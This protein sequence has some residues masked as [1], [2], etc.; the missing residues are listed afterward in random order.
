MVVCQICGNKGYSKLLIHCVQ[1]QDVA[2]H[3][4]CV[5]SPL[6]FEDEEL[7]WSC[8][9]CEPG[10]TKPTTPNKKSESLGASVEQTALQKTVP[11]KLRN[12][13]RLKKS[14]VALQG[15]TK[16]NTDLSIVNQKNR[17][18]TVR[19]KRAK[20]KKTG[21]TNVSECK[22]EL[23]EGKKRP[24]QPKRPV[25][26]KKGKSIKD[27][28]SD[29]GVKKGRFVSVNDT[30]QN[31]K[32]VSL[33]DTAGD[34]LVKTGK[35]VGP[36][37]TEVNVSTCIAGDG[38]QGD[39]KL[40]KQQKRTRRLRP[41]KKIH[42]EKSSCEVFPEHL[43]ELDTSKNQP[44]NA[45]LA[46]TAGDGSQ[47]DSKL[48]KQQKLT[49]CSLPKK[50]IHTEKSSCEVF[51]EHLQESDICK[52]Q[53]RNADLADT[54][55]ESNNG[56]S[57][58]AKQQNL[59]SRLLPKK[60]IHI[61][62]SSCEVFSEH[63]K[64]S[65]TS[66]NQP[67]NADLAD[68]AGDGSQGASKSVKQQKPTSRSLPKKKIDTEKSS[69]EDFSKHLKE[70]D[71]SENQPRNTVLA[72]HADKRKPGVEETAV[73]LRQQDDVQPNRDVS[74]CRAPRRKRKYVIEM[75][76]S[77]EDPV[78]VVAEH[79]RLLT[80][81]AKYPLSKSSNGALSKLS[82]DGLPQLSS[83]ESVPTRPSPRKV[84]DRLL[85][86]E[87]SVVFDNYISSQPSTSLVDHF[88]TQPLIDV[89]WRGY[90]DID[91]NEYLMSL[92]LRAHL[93]NKAHE[94][95]HDAVTLLPKL[96]NFNFVPK[97]YAWPK[98]FEESP[99]T[100]NAIGLYLFPDDERAEELYDGLVHKM[101]D[102]DLALNSIVD[103]LE[104]LV[105]CSIE[106]PRE[107]WSFM[108]KYYLWGVFR[109]MKD[110]IMPNTQFSNN[111]NPSDSFYHQNPSSRF[112]NTYFRQEPV[113]QLVNLTRPI[114]PNPHYRPYNNLS[115]DNHWKHS[116]G[117]FWEPQEHEHG[118]DDYLPDY[119]ERNRYYR[120][121]QEHEHRHDADFSDYG[122]RN[123]YYRGRSDRRNKRAKNWN[124]RDRKYA[125]HSHKLY[126]QSG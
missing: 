112:P 5:L 28:I 21:S 27:S 81:V 13:S 49:S 93:S 69:C 19:R 101:I 115:F 106:L 73:V 78:F 122:K 91:D 65:D 26:A 70:S 74:E 79:S 63:S 126:L 36:L 82:D 108:G 90:C 9:F 92:I 2:A 76:Y 98:S 62:K 4:Y 40:V 107:E 58:L 6:V 86:Q 52:N 7:N 66:K 85:T 124:D 29:K 42:I 44:G 47:G 99:P 68:T 94:N 20:P 16:G 77:D 38:N 57:K 95:V 31:I 125:G 56:V 23:S 34:Q 14:N 113:E 45:D 1:C 67:R 35:D 60:K 33:S 55:G 39:S 30:E 37:L 50:K 88:L 117:E 12:N 110:P 72:D 10:K 51:P 24:G 120:E 96:L 11:K 54:A 32:N 87:T 121:P 118:H 61:E 84:E 48:V 100:S 59:T 18:V 8:E 43:K 53:P 104:L 123:R 75:E 71:I 116:R 3:R 103:N 22:Q 114:S 111:F 105:F 80:D 41:K 17:D 83:V 109:P 119:G 97:K 25:A 46:D 89:A 15:T 64:E 102:Y